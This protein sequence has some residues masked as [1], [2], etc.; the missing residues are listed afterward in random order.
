MTQMNTKDMST[1]I[2][3]HSTL[4]AKVNTKQ[5]SKMDRSLL[6]TTP[7]ADYENFS[8]SVGATRHAQAIPRESFDTSFNSTPRTIDVHDTR[9]PTPSTLFTSAMELF[10]RNH[11]SYSR[12]ASVTPTQQQQQH[13]PIMDAV[14]NRKSMSQTDTQPFGIK[15]ASKTK[16]QEH[17]RQLRKLNANST[18]VA[19][20]SWRKK[21]LQRLTNLISSRSSSLVSSSTSSS[22]NLLT[23][24]SE[25]DPEVTQEFDQD[26]AQAIIAVGGKLLDIPH[27]DLLSSTGLRRLVA[28]NIQWFQ[29][30]PDCIK[31]IGLMLAK[32]LNSTITGH[33][34]RFEEIDIDLPNTADDLELILP[35]E[36]IRKSHPIPM[37]SHS[38]DHNSQ[39]QVI[40]GQPP[41]DTL[42]VMH[43]VV[44]DASS[45]SPSNAEPVSAQNSSESSP[46]STSSSS[47]LSHPS[48]TTV[49]QEWHDVPPLATVMKSSRRANK[50]AKTNQEDIKSD[51][52]V[53]KSS[54]RV[55]PT[56][57]VK[58]EIPKKREVKKGKNTK[59]TDDML[60]TVTGQEKTTEVQKIVVK[61][62]DEAMDD[63]VAMVSSVVSV[64]NQ[65][66]GQ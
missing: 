13:Q 30:T 23:G 56:R 11:A 60:G 57:Q 26:I 58:N 18:I 7:G 36:H 34:R 44:A 24:Y 16:L 27:E 62:E 65:Q 5:K 49:D 35:V 25:I 31:L 4:D 46:V 20:P 21:A 45:I 66:D 40:I 53:K 2:R 10:K 54:Q 63:D 41:T 33:K 3:G 12:S 48:T 22:T 51:K 59:T 47:S 55:K 43:D 50:K 9:I 6:A 32:K 1:Y 38:L 28:R 29:H 42:S 19:A 8:T 37:A 14:Q 61:Q 17:Q 15:Q 52:D 64:S 39:E